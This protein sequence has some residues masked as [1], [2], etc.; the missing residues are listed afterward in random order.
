MATPRAVNQRIELAPLQSIQLHPILNVSGRASHII[1]L[2]T[3]SQR[4]SV[5]FALV[6]T[7]NLV[8]LI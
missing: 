6:C 2:G 7:E 1:E 5:N 4:I 3:G 8:R